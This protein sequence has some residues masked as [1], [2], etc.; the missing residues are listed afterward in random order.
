MLICEKSHFLTFCPFTIHSN[1][2]GGFEGADSQVKFNK[3]P[4]LYT[5]FPLLSTD[6]PN[7]PPPSMIGLESGPGNSLKF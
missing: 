7:S 6:P 3:S 4:G 1:V 2:A 5:A